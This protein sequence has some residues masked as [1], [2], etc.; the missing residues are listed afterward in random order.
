MNNLSIKDSIKFGW[1]KTKESL[2]FLV[3]FQIVFYLINMLTDNSIFGFIVSLLTG[4]VF[5]SVILR[6]SRNEKVVFKNIFDGISLKTVLH[7]FLTTVIVS[8]LVFT[9]LI[10]LI[11]PGII[12]SL[13]TCFASF[14]II[15]NKNPSWPALSFWQ[16]VKESK[17]ITKGYKW[18]LF[19]FMMVAVLVNILGLLCLGVGMLV[20]IPVTTIAFAFV[21]EKIKNISVTSDNLITATN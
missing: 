9:G 10:L 21:Y 4:L 13:M 18:F 1:Q 6:I 2:W 11:V 16:A 20:S 3:G 8:V 17:K 12:L 14:L 15:D 7:Y 19:K 5:T